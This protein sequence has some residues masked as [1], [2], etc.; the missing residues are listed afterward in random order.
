[1]QSFCNFVLHPWST[2]HWSAPNP[3]LVITTSLKKPP[4]EVV[5]LSRTITFLYF[6]EK[7]CRE[8]L[9]VLSTTLG[10]EGN[11]S[12][13]STLGGLQGQEPGSVTRAQS[14]VHFAHSWVGN[15]LTAF[16]LQFV[17]LSLIWLDTKKG[18]V[19]KKASSDCPALP[20]L[21]VL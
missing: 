4:P 5:K 13:W 16:P 19:A 7:T 10:L 3:L 6:Q 8:K 11:T 20:Y 2:H 9:D 17:L 12:L 18:W 1:M 15:L 21:V 14:L